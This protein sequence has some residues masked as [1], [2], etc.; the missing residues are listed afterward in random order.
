[1]QP[2]IIGLGA[3]PQ[4]KLAIIDGP[5]DPSANPRSPQTIII[6]LVCPDH[7]ISDPSRKAFPQNN[8]Q[9]P[10]TCSGPAPTGNDPCQCS[11]REERAERDPPLKSPPRARGVEM[12]VFTADLVTVY[13]RRQAKILILTFF[14]YAALC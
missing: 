11:C 12:L 4:Q 1:M 9:R 5:A 6:G 10:I 7:H 8:L 2:G 3:R 13:F 14:T